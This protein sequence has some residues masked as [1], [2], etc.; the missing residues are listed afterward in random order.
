ML[1]FQEIIKLFDFV[2]LYFTEL[3]HFKLLTVVTQTS[4]ILR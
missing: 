2:K 3:L 4:P 1:I